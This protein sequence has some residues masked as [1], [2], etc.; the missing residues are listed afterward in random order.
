MVAGRDADARIAFEALVARVPRSV[1]AHLSLGW[2]AWN[3]QDAAGAR[4]HL[5][6]VDALSP[7]NPDALALRGNVL[8]ATGDR[9]SATAAWDQALASGDRVDALSGLARAALVGGQP[10][11]GLEFADRAVAMSPDD[12]SLLS[13]HSQLQS[14]L[15]HDAG[16]R[17]D[18]DAAIALSPDPWLRVDR[19]RLLWRTF[20]D[21][22]SARA[23]LE[24][25]V[26]ALPDQV[27]AWAQLGEVAEAQNDTP[28]A[29]QAWQRV[30]ALRPDYRWAYPSASV[31]AFR[32]QD[33]EKA[34]VYSRE[35]AKDYPGEFAF[36]F[37][38]ALSLRF[39]GQPDAAQT[40]LT[41][42]QKRFPRGSTVD[43][44]FRFLLTP[45]SDYAFNTA[46]KLETN[47]SLRLR[48]RFY[49]G[50][51]Y[52]QAHLDRSALACFQEV[53]DGTSPNLPEVASAQ[54]WMA[55]GH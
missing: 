8:W 15:G 53:A 32:L 1:E 54:A 14:A 36:P 39:L 29:Y 37:A 18:L 16:A 19:G 13:L 43:E 22:P 5:D 47:D 26:A 52:V 41:S 50:C 46:M 20:H 10:S 40:V 9:A 21:A 30:L 31:L 33:F 55:H 23:D 25:A 44:A 7:G 27:L 34:V 2:L 49:Q 6:V 4:V 28:R 48:L 11:R 17:A 38:Q 12:P 35:A 42:A 45:G 51:S 3:R 24:A